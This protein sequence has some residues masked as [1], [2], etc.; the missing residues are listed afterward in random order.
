MWGAAGGNG[1]PNNALNDAGGTGAFASGVIFVTGGETLRLTAAS[2]AMNRTVVGVGGGGGFNGALGGGMSAIER[3]NGAAF[4]P[5]IIAGGGGAGGG[6]GRGP[7]T[8]ATAN[9]TLCATAARFGGFTSSASPPGGGGSGGGAC[10]GAPSIYGGFGGSSF[11]DVT[12]ACGLALTIPP[13]TPPQFSS[14]WDGNAGLRNPPGVH[15]VSGNGRIV[16][17]LLPSTYVPCQMYFASPT[18]S[19]SATYSRTVASSFSRTVAYSPTVSPSVS[20]SI[21]ARA[22]LSATTTPV[23]PGGFFCRGSSPPSLCP[24]GHYCP[25]GSTQWRDKNCGRNNYCPWG[26]SAPIP[27]P[28]KGTVDAVLGPANGAYVIYHSWMPS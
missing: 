11:I 25:A 4:I 18:Q 26:S 19:V 22:S 10:G 27:C 15:G 1:W 8:S 20:T 7:G 14:N 21:K 5:A 2:S 28:P 17:T 3:W 24:A 12:V 9:G 13:T 23:C 6:D 16:L